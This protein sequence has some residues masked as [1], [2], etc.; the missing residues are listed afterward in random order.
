M[1]RIGRLP[2]AV[3]G[4]VAVAFR[5]GVFTAKGPLGEL[6]VRIPAEMD[7]KVGD[8]EVR[9]SRP[10]D[11]K[12][13]RSLHGL[14]RSLVNS[15]V[16]GVSKGYSK[17]LEIVGV[18]YRAEK[19]GKVLV[20]HLG[21][22]HPIVLDPPPGIEF[23]TPEPTRIVVKGASKQAV[24]QMAADIRGKRPPEPYKGKGVKYAGEQIR[25]KAGKT[26]AG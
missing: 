23:E 14:S 13:H 19:K 16:I 18:G 17:T 3:P 9:V 7:V 12:P 1:S 25:R 4:G 15:A 6:S 11:S 21:Y 24:G 5:E 26:A 2:V 20:M 22:S 10:S 8:G